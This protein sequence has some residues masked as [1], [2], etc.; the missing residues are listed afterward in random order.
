[1]P[2]ARADL[3]PYDYKNNEIRDDE[4]RLLILDRESED[5]R[6]SE[7]FGQLKPF[8]LTINPPSDPGKKHPNEACRYEALSYT[9]GDSQSETGTNSEIF[10]RKKK[11]T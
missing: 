2:V 1:M 6:N 4:I 11:L 7:L 10:S 3:R 9:W 5:G 8:T